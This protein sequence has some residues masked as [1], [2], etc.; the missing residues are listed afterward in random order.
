MSELARPRVI[1]RLHEDPASEGAQSPVE[2]LKRRDPAAFARIVRQ[3]GALRLEPVFSG[4]VRET[5]PR[6]QK[7]AVARDPTY[8]PVDLKAFYYV[9]AERAEDLEK[10]ARLLEASAGVLSAEVEVPGPDPVVNAADDPRAVDQGYL[11]VAPGGI[12]ARYA[13]TFP[14]GDGAGQTICDIEQGWTVNHE[15]L[16]AHT[17]TQ[18][19]GTIVNSSRGHGTSVL[20]ELCAVDNNLGCVGIAPNV[21]TIFI[22]S[23][24]PSLANSIV[25]VLGSLDF[26]DIILLETQD[27]VPGNA[28]LLGP[29]E[30]VAATWE[31]IRLAT[32]LGVIV[33]EAGGNGT[34]NGGTPAV[35]L[36]TQV[37]GNGTLKF[38]RDAGNAAFRDSGAIIVAAA[39]SAAPHTR[40]AFSTHGRRVDCFAWGHNITT[41]TSDANG[42]TTTY[43]NDFGGTSGAS[44]MVAG[45]ALCVQGIYEAATGNRLSPRQMRRILSDPAINT[46]KS[47]NEATD[48]GVMPNLR[49]I[50][51]DVLGAVPDVYLRDFVGDD[52]D[53]HNGSISAS[54][55][56]ILRPAAV[57]DPQT[58]FGE[59][60]GTENNASLGFE[61]EAGQDN[62]VYVRCRNRGAVDAANVNAQVFWAPPSTLVT[63]DQWNPVGVG[64]V[65]LP[66]VPAT[67]ALTCSD[68]LV[69]PAAQIPAPGHYCFVG[70]LGTADDPAPL[71]AAFQD[72]DNFRT[73]IRSLNNVTWRN[74]NVID[75]DPGDPSPAADMAWLMPGAPDRRARF[76]LELV[77]RL[78]RRAEVFWELPLRFLREFDAQLKLVSVDEKNGRA[79]VSLPPRGKLSFGP[80]LMPAKARHQMRFK[81]KLNEKVRQAVYR[82]EARQLFEG[83]EEVGRLSWLFHPKRKPGK[84][85]KG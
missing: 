17:I 50:I 40:R 15:D 73:F 7:L 39:S 37:D 80:A 77:L 24:N 55:D 10:L 82:I 16:A 27:G 31:S 48:M 13:W 44:P 6:L 75:V 19:N 69:W 14:G 74:F 20:G 51:D 26:G 43:R 45:A 28:N 5:L 60:S 9:E 62:F 58:E 53:P 76:S 46:L 83:R 11:D 22:A 41:L 4:K 68:A 67:D 57:A 59:G 35:N 78:P 72:F 1:V 12:D 2:H 64:S 34:G 3:V 25:D 63:P 81:V 47:A 85:K 61:A 23:R 36:D 30:V 8:E 49:R 29:S 79:V 32:A 42:A 18:L 56:I 33:V 66:A 38:F 65:T 52:G 21:G 54:P 84:G 71:P 70:I